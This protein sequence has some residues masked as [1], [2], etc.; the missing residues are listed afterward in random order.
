[1]SESAEAA[2]EAE[3]AAMNMGDRIIKANAEIL[4]ELYSATAANGP[5]NSCHEGYAVMKEEV[6]ELWDEVKKKP[7]ARSREKLRAEA[8]QIGAMALRFMIDCADEPPASK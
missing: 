3:R 2:A 6:D 4:R 7:S 8:K 5:F 1:M